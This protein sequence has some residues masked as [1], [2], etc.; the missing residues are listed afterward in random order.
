MRRIA[1]VPSKECREVFQ[2]LRM[3]QWYSKA[4]YRTFGVFDTTDLRRINV[5]CGGT[6]QN[7]HTC[8]LCAIR[9][10]KYVGEFT[11]RAL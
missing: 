8:A 3:E 2:V 4:F 9:V 6:H 10:Q 5:A 11:H 1:A 7:H